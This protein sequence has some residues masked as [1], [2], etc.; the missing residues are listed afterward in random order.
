VT[1]FCRGA[2]VV[3]VVAVLVSFFTVSTA[4]AVV[5]GESCPRGS[6]YS[7]C[8]A[9]WEISSHVEP[10]NIEPGGRGQIILYLADV[11][12]ANT[13]PGQPITVTDHLPEGV[14]A[15][16]AEAL[17]EVGG[18]LWECTGAGTSE[19]K[20]TNNPTTLS[21]FYGGGAPPYFF[22]ENELLQVTPPVKIEVE[23]AGGERV[24][25]NHAT[26]SGGGAFE[27]ASTSGPLVVSS[28]PAHFGIANLDA[29]MSNADGTIDTQAGSHPM[30]LR[31]M[32][33]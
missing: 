31:S 3:V 8:S 16:A 33:R 2:T 22:T 32:C 9:G 1:G 30:R 29:W 7:A 21:S 17:Y 12:A 11:G 10:T 26:V 20:C 23:V 28:T 24:G 13:E 4:S 25:E 15:T 19:V 14:T 6:E 18:A 27:G 5:P